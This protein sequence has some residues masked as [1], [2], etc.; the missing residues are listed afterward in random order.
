M[1]TPRH[2]GFLDLPPELRLAIYEQLP[3]STVSVVQRLP[4]DC[5]LLFTAPKCQTALLAT[6]KI[7]NEEAAPVL[8]KV[9]MELQPQ[10]TFSLQNRTNTHCHSSVSLEAPLLAKIVLTMAKF[11][12]DEHLSSLYNGST[13]NRLALAM[14]WRDIL[15][16]YFV[17]EQ[18]K[19]V[20][21]CNFCADAT[22]HLRMTGR[23]L[24]LQ[25]HCAC[26]TMS[27]RLAPRV[28]DYFRD[29]NIYPGLSVV[30]LDAESDLSGQDVVGGG[31]GA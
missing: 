22:Q 31:G 4:N 28:R 26:P 8:Q 18:Y 3:T 10:I 12:F 11:R 23:D 16:P 24:S 19:L 13:T 1:S 29:S 27:A 25:F 20:R 21:L 17:R 14:L 15:R 6:C 7:I 9:M 2:L 5:S 30:I